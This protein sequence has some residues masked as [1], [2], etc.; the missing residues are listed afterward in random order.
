[1]K[2]NYTYDIIVRKAQLP[3]P[4]QDDDQ[5]EPERTFSVRMLDDFVD[6]TPN[7]VLVQNFPNQN[8]GEFVTSPCDLIGAL[9][10]RGIC[11]SV[12]DD[13]Q[14]LGSGNAMVSDA[15]L[16][17]LVTQTFKTT[18]VVNVKI[19]RGKREIGSLELSLKIS[20]TDPD[21][22]T[23]LQHF[24]CYDICRPLDKSVN[25]RDVIFTMGR[26][27]KC[28]AT[29][30]ITDER[31]MSHA[32]APFNCLHEAGGPK[33][34]CGCFIPG[35]KA[36]PGLDQAKEREQ[37]LL[38]KLLTELDVDREHVPT[39]PP[40][41]ALSRQQRCQCKSSDSSYFSPMEFWSDALDTD[42]DE[43]FDDDCELEPDLLPHQIEE[44]EAKRKKALGVCPQI[45]APSLTNV[46]YKPPNL[47]PVCNANITWLPKL[48][49]CPY[50]GYKRFDMEKPSEEPFDETATAAEV[51][52]N[53]ILQ[54]RFDGDKPAPKCDAGQDGGGDAP[55]VPS[56]KLTK[57]CTCSSDR[58]C[59]RC[60]IRELCE[61]VFQTEAKSK[62]L[63]LP[64][65]PPASVKAVKKK[66]STP[67]Q[68]R[69]QLVNIFTE[70]RDNYAG[71]E[72]TAQQ[73]CAAVKSRKGGKGKRT[74]PAV[75]KLL[76]EM[77]RSFPCKPKKKAKKNRKAKR[78]SRSKR[79]TFLEPKPPV[80]PVTTHQSCA[81]DRGRVP[82][83]MGWKWTASELARHRCWKPGAIM[84]PIRQLMA[85]FLRD[86]PADVVGITKRHCRW[87]GQSQDG[88]E[89]ESL[90][91]HPTLHIVKKH[92]EYIITL[93]PLKDPKT[94]AVAANPYANMKPV[95]FRIVK[96]PIAAGER[97]I[98]TTLKDEL[99]YA[100]CTCNQPIAECFCRSHVDKLI[101]QQA[102]R[103]LAEARG[104]QDIS[105][106]FVFNDLSES[107]SENE[108]DFGVTPPAGVVKPERLRQP[109]RAHCETQYDSNDCA[110]PTMF[111]HPPTALVQY[112]GCVVGERRGR[113]PWIMGKGFVHR[114]PKPAKKINKPPKQKK[115][116]KG[117]QKGGC[118]AGHF[119]G[120]YLPFHRNWHKSN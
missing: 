35:V 31:L 52:R 21:L 113:F 51:L 47:C 110:M 30:C 26:S 111:P 82:C 28:A 56:Y 86:Y 20:S 69:E 108:L 29:T 17:K 57:E 61:Q 117:R 118:D 55:S 13:G 34:E 25:P 46:K 93:R 1:M 36:P 90:V 41:H 99:G 119:T 38:K 105:D 74:S 14:I 84:K 24:G 79:Y 87:R 2:Q 49:A 11:V 22:D 116:K 12:Y 45:A 9:S 32:G 89:E 6:L 23:R 66:A 75:K 15:L 88:V 7:R 100:V 120:N 81:G 50:C 44:L 77:A 54:T 64:A 58:V 5:E 59:T 107:D 72:K 16:R 114:E 85:Y 106:S 48:A 60:R 33:E 18:E 8:M 94:L 96:D 39:P 97:E 73:E 27:G 42:S 63:T 115:S 40:E 43:D 37:K 71:K 4:E 80:N 53:H 10:S 76:K 78:R 3:R 103:S 70:M 101:V 91:Q 62:T 95:V 104:W 19:T 92:D 98:K 67:S 83:N 112:G 65:S 102:V 68:H 109:D